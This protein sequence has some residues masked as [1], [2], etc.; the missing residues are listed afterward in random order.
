MRWVDGSEIDLKQF[1][2]KEI[3]EK[4]SMEMWNSYYEQWIK[5]AEF[6]Q[7]AI[8][9]VDFDSLATGGFTTPSFVNFID[10]YYWQIIKAFRAI[11]DK[12]DA[13]IL[14]ELSRLDTHYQKLLGSAKDDDEWDK[15]YDEFREKIDAL[16][17]KL[18]LNTDFDMWALLYKYLDEQISKL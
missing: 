5:C 14:T 4:L 7:N 6:L 13:E 15:I 16:E 17:K 3:C 10:E 8:F 12:K 11:G 1:S 9:I 2:G 18:Y